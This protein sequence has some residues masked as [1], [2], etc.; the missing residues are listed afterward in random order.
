MFRIY[1]G[2]RW[3]CPGMRPPRPPRNTQDMNTDA[4]TDTDADA[5]ADART[6][7]RADPAVL[8]HQPIPGAGAAGL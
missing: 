3:Q 5:D 1:A 4:D 8:Q 7:P 6:L 2:E